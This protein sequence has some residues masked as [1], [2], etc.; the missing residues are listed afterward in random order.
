[1]ATEL[2]DM[3][4]TLALHTDTTLVERRLK[5]LKS[6]IYSV[7][8]YDSYNDKIIGVDMFFDKSARY[9]LRKFVKSSQL[10]LL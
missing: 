8:Y 3:K 2:R 6:Y 1:M 5:K 4:N 7:P 10:P 9:T